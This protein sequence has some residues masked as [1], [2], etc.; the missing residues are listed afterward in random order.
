MTF[1]Y[2]I[3]ALSVGLIFYSYKLFQ[4]KNLLYKFLAVFCIVIYHLMM[5]VFFAQEITLKNVLLFGAIWVI[6]LFICMVILYLMRGIKSPF[7]T[8]SGAFFWF[9]LII[10]YFTLFQSNLSEEWMVIW[11][12]VGLFF[13]GT[14]FSCFSFNKYW[15]F[16]FVFPYIFVPLATFFA[17]IKMEFLKGQTSMLQLSI[18]IGIS[19]LGS[20]F[21]FK[22]KIYRKR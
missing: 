6:P 1:T 15:N 22:K 12:N 8:Y 5:T 14:L 18:I 10:I 4:E 19:L 11:L 3:I 21:F 9:T 7:K 20:V 17:T 16:I 13:F 2:L